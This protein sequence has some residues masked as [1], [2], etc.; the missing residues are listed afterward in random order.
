M[1]GNQ[2]DFSKFAD[3]QIQ[4]GKER[5]EEEKEMRNERNERKEKEKGGGQQ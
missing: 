2:A 1:P 5:E 3:E 4:V